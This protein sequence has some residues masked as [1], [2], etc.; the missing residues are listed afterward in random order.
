[1]VRPLT[2]K[3]KKGRLY[4][5]GGAMDARIDSALTQDLPT[6][7]RRT[8]VT[9]ALS[10]D[11]LPSECLVHLI[12]DAIRR[13]D[14]RRY[15]ALMTPLLQRCEANLEKTVPDGRLRNAVAVRE[16]IISAFGLMFAEDGLEGHE[17]ALDYYECRFGRAFRSLRIGFVRVEIAERKEVTELPQSADEDGTPAFDDE[18][19]GRLSSMARINGAQEDA[20]Y[21]PHVLNAVNELPHD[22]KRAV[23]L[24]RILGYEAES[25]DSSKRTAATICEVEGRTIRYRLSRADKQLKTLKEDL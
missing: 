13:S 7:A 11:F 23:V 25:P 4:T 1:M 20:L 8:R 14:E 22:Q 21:L 12:R 3:T 2:R 6:L 9:D 16:E 17:D 15:N 24:V 19:L 10:S 18:T 5:R